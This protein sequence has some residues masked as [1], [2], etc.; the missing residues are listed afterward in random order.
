MLELGG[1]A[2]RADGSENEQRVSGMGLVEASRLA[3]GN[4][5]GAEAIEQ[6]DDERDLIPMSIGD[7]IKIDD[8][9][10]AAKSNDYVEDNRDGAKAVA[11][12]CLISL[13]I[14]LAATGAV[15][16]S[17][18][19]MVLTTR[20]MD[21]AVVEGRGVPKE[22]TESMAEME[23]YRWYYIGGAALTIVICVAAALG[24]LCHF[25]VSPC[26]WRTFM[27]MHQGLN[28]IFELFE[29]P[30][31]GWDDGFFGLRVA[32]LRN[33]GHSCGDCGDSSMASLPWRLL[34]GVH[35]SL[36]WL[37][38]HHCRISRKHRDRNSAA[39][40]CCHVACVC[41]GVLLCMERL[42]LAARTRREAK[43]GR[44]EGEAAAQRMMPS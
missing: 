13:I 33:S 22:L 42:G 24:M 40:F 14:A 12:T 16:Y 3:A 15:L 21:E 31:A 9:N 25:I 18:I 19:R 38:L 17:E 37:P 39:C 36:D 5:T 43:E 27:W 11:W 28:H 26:P 2:V 20:S 30:N 7:K 6:G 41:H 10:F 44:G 23:S 35:A 29:P 4:E 1:R 34:L 32:G 8:G